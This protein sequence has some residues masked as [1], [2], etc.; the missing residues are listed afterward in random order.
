V[1]VPAPAGRPGGAARLLPA[2]A[3]LAAYQRPW[4]GVDV[5]AGL[6][7]GAIVIPKAMAYATIAGL[8]LQVGL[9]TAFLPMVVYAALGTSRV[10][11]VSTTTTLAI[12]SAAA[13]GEALQAHPGLEPATA[14]AT[15]AVLVGGL[16]L[17]ARVLRLGFVANFIS[18]PVLTGFK[19]GIG[20]VIVVDQVPKLLGLHLQKAGWFRDVASIVRHVPETS[21]ATLLVALG[22]FAVIVLLERHLPRAPAPLL[23][24]AAG[25]G[26]SAALGLSAR[27]V[28][29]VGTIPG[30]IPGLVRPDLSLML[31]LW[32]AAAG[33]ALMSFTETIAAAR[34][35]ARQGDPRP[36]SNQELVGLGAANV[37][38]GL[39]G[40]MP[41]GGGTSQ[42]AV[43]ANAGARTQ[44]SALATAAMAVAT[45]LFL[46]PVLG[47]MPN[48][49]LAAVVIA[50]SVGLIQLGDFRAI[51]SIRT[52][53]FHWALAA[54]LGVMVLGTLRGI[55]A[56]VVLSMASLL[57]LASTPPVRVMGRKPGTSIFRA[58][59]AEHPEDESFPGLLIARP[60][61][62][63]YFGNAAAVAE[64]IRQLVAE[65]RPRVL[66]LDLGAVPG[67]EY[68][69]LQMLVAADDRLRE[70]GLEL[71]LAR[72]NPDALELVKRTP[73][74][75]RLGRER[76]H[77]TVQAAVEAWQERQARTA[78]LGG[79]AQ[80]PAVAP[81]ATDRRLSGP[82]S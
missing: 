82:G 36:D 75:D 12:L 71:W 69:A 15:L 46:A 23:A 52:M 43:N 10:L 56:A 37:V 31:E 34:A 26:A 81:E 77:L 29:V 21:V 13:M 70:Q 45:M 1:T 79:G 2:L 50:Y 48:A 44:V 7:A 42:T 63:L 66:L 64:R 47:P 17:L 53:E 14:T 76:M 27:G 33:I 62:R 8:P 4:L 72:L 30:G 24:V 58:R 18:D 32:P 61:G 20:L 57:Y 35:F 28:G 80:P 49:T 41:C 3:W 39:F 59:S 67:L 19:A 11:S 54:C 22:T 55:L 9:Y 68:T 6:T 38:G 5:V 78:D 16:L 25:I 51:R 60:E 40:A 74:A 73:L 65:H